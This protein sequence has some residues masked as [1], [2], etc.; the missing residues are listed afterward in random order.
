MSWRLTCDP[1]RPDSRVILDVVRALEDDLTVVMPTETQYAL[2]M[3]AD[4]E[5]APE[6]IGRIKKRSGVVPAAVFVKDIQMAELFCEVS[7]M[8][9]RLAARFLPG[10]L[11]LVLSARAGQRAVAA[12]FASED[13]FGIRISSS[14]LVAA[15]MAKTPFP[16]TA[17]S[18]N[19]SGEISP[20]TVNEIAKVLGDDVDLYV[21]GG[22]CRGVVPSTVL[23]VTD[24]VSVLR[25]GAIP[26]AEIRRFLKEGR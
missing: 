18:A 24:T 20:A 14:P 16:V 13:G 4:R 26:E 17:T 12:G 3:R 21:D 2:S 6:K 23:K 15:L 10:P 9:R 1:A 25:H 7:D 8:A 22:P 11:T 5:N 19:I